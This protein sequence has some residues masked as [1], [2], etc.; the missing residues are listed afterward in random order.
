[1]DFGYLAGLTE[2]E[3]LAGCVLIELAYR[4]D[5]ENVVPKGTVVTD[6]GDPFRFEAVIATYLARRHIRTRVCSL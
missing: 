3:K 5:D 1:M 2:A 6:G 4:D